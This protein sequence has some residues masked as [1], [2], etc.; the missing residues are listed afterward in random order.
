V[1]GKKGKNQWE[2]GRDWGGRKGR[3]GEA[4]G[5][6]RAGFGEWKIIEGRM[7]NCSEDW[8]S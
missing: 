1:D 8:N 5:G 7:K 4:E 3:R 2:G 6:G